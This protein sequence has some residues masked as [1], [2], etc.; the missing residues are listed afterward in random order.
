MDP[1]REKRTV[2][3]F[4]LQPFSSQA[5]DEAVFRDKSFRQEAISEDQR[6]L[7]V[8]IGFCGEKQPNLILPF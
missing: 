5:R 2:Q 3:K 7:K 4:H 1:E 6:N 8:F